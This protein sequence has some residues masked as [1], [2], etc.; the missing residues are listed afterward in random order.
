MAKVYTTPSC[1]KCACVVLVELRG[2][3]AIKGGEFSR[4]VE[5]GEL[6]MRVTESHRVFVGR[7]RRRQVCGAWGELP[8]V[9]ATAERANDGDWNRTSNAGRTGEGH[10]WTGD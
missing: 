8:T 6:P 9:V 10:H 5:V 7:P 1:L 2:A 3:C 4:K